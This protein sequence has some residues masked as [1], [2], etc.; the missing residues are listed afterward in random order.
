VLT[1]QWSCEQDEWLRSLEK[2]DPLGRHFSDILFREPRDEEP[3]T[4]ADLTHHVEQHMDLMRLLMLRWLFFDGVWYSGHPD[5]HEMDFMVHR[6]FRADPRDMEE[7]HRRHYQSLAPDS[8]DA[9]TMFQLKQQQLLNHLLWRETIRR[10][11]QAVQARPNEEPRALLHL[12]DQDSIEDSERTAMIHRCVQ[13]LHRLCRR[14]QDAP[15]MSPRSMHRLIDA[16]DMTYNRQAVNGLGDRLHHIFQAA[17]ADPKMIP[18]S[19]CRLLDRNT[20]FRFGADLSLDVFFDYRIAHRLWR[21]GGLPLLPHCATPEWLLEDDH[22]L[23]KIFD[24]DSGKFIY[25]R[26]WLLV[27]A[28][29]H[30]Q[31][32]WRVIMRVTTSLMRTSRALP[33]TAMVRPNECLSCLAL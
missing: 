21:G 29:S 24:A 31:A 25:L 30:I 23:G 15:H 10:F 2:M 19:F 14:V 11:F 22:F 28:W 17:Q 32:N 12:L 13:E 20:V 9:S 3:T 27:R 33:P 1:I 6:L 4:Y 26:S 7:L 16:E 8:K 18:S 5:G